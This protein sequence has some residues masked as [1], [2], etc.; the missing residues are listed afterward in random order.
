L[1]EPAFQFAATAISACHCNL[2]TVFEG[3]DGARELAPLA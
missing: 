2:F 3:R 1:A